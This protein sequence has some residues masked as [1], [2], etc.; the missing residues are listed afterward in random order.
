[1]VNLRVIVLTVVV[2]DEDLGR[3]RD[4]ILS[5][6]AQGMSGSV[7]MGF[8]LSYRITERGADKTEA[9]RYLNSF[10]PDAE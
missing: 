4:M 3:A 6:H 5:G 2:L 8:D 9:D 1:V 7:C 10:P